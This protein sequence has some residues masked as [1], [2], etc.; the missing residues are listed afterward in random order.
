M[1]FAHMNL[2]DHFIKSHNLCA[3]WDIIW[4]SGFRNAFRRWRAMTNSPSR[5]DKPI[6][7]GRWFPAPVLGGEG[8]INA[9]I[10][11]HKRALTNNKVYHL[12]IP[13]SF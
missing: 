10:G 4:R 13:M 3:I 7:E 12:N 11:D 6:Q 9:T 8:I 5:K 1:T 2:I